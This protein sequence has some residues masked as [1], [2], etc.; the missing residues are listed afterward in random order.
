MNQSVVKTEQKD[1]INDSFEELIYSRSHD[2][3]AD[4][5]GTSTISNSSKVDTNGTIHAFSYSSS[6]VDWSLDGTI[7]PAPRKNDHTIVPAGKTETR[8]TSGSD[9]I[10]VATPNF[11]DNV[12]GDFYFLSDNVQNRNTFRHAGNNNSWFASKSTFKDKSM[13][14]PSRMMNTTTTTTGNIRSSPGTTPVHNKTHS[15][16]SVGETMNVSA[17]RNIRPTRSTGN[18]AN[19]SESPSPTLHTRSD[20]G[21]FHTDTP[22][23]TTKGPEAAERSKSLTLVDWT[24]DLPVNTN[25]L[26]N[27]PYENETTTY[28]RLCGVHGA[29]RNNNNENQHLPNE[30]CDDDASLRLLKSDQRN[31]LF[32]GCVRFLLE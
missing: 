11:L 3:K 5:F 6:A 30:H 23:L 32:R 4:I 29:K 9:C 22:M 7:V 28:C 24:K 12:D 1:N 25:M 14:V 16:T 31:G 27:D 15:C 18:D 2:W 17:Q 8:S 20:Q 10:H 13:T 19:V 26:W 21:T